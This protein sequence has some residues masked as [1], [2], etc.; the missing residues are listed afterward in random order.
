MAGAANSSL[1]DAWKMLVV[2]YACCRSFVVFPDRALMQSRWNIHLYVLRNI[3]YIAR[4]GALD[5]EVSLSSDVCPSRFHRFCSRMPKSSPTRWLY[6]FSK[7]F[8]LA[9]QM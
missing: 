7:Y 5:L 8:A 1:S 4:G 9:V 2:K 6:F 3:P